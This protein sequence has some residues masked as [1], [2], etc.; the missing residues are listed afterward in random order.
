M[1][2]SVNMN[3]YINCENGVQLIYE[4]IKDSDFNSIEIWLKFGSSQD[5][6]DNIGIAH[7]IEHLLIP[8][9]LET[10]DLY[11][12][13]NAYAM[14]SKERIRLYTK[15]KKEKT[16]NILE[17]FL[18]NIT[19]LCSSE[20]NFEYQKLK[21]I[22]E[23]LYIKKSPIVL[24]I[25]DAERELFK[26]TGYSNL[27]FG[28]EKGL[29]TIDLCFIRNY[30]K[31]LLKENG[32]IISITGSIDVNEVKSLINNNLP[33]LNSKNPILCRDTFD[34][35][36]INSNLNS[37]GALYIYNTKRNDIESNLNYILD[38]FLEELLKY[39]FRTS[40]FYTKKID[41]NFYKL[42][43]IYIPNIISNKYL[44]NEINNL[45]TEKI[46]TLVFDIIKSYICDT[47]EYMKS[48]C[49]NLA[50]FNA[51]QI[52]HSRNY[53]IDKFLLTLNSININSLEEHISLIINK[54][55]SIKVI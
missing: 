14:T 10:I 36:T 17:C 15:V 20:Y 37:S 53:D 27:T 35:I 30:L 16:L 12:R 31:T 34:S 41:Y 2:G 50:H 45:N 48:S 5:P 40:I 26:N 39:K 7:L 25:E 51:N 28:E 11:A 4:N 44:A 42:L 52:F 18:N 8:E 46:D 32:V 21:V 3:T 24:Y 29:N 13:K 9:K 19:D 38:I 6:K 23:I 49:D 1:Q 54:N 55:K 43:T 33:N 47:Y 22:Q